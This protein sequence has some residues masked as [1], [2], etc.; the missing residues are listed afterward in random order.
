M[1]LVYKFDAKGASGNCYH[2]HVYHD[3]ITASSANGEVNELPGPKSY[4]LSDGRAL[5]QLS[6]TKFEIVHTS[7]K[8]FRV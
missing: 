6:E 3:P 2:V 1:D 5:H 7:E 4:Q 8:I